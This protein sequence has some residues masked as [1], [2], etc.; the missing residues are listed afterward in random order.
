[1][2]RISEP[3]K[4]TASNAWG[5]DATSIITHYEIEE[6]D[7]GATRPHHGGYRHSERTFGRADVGRV[8]AVYT[9]GTNWTCW[10]FELHPAGV[11]RKDEQGEQCPDCG[12]HTVKAQPGGGV[13]CGHPG[14]GYWFCF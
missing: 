9:D 12:N 1:M 8:I 6:G 11:G 13:K 7:V 5:H 3:R 2:K 14:C 10:V 4:F